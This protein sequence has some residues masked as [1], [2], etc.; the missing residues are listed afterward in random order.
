MKVTSFN[1]GKIMQ[2]LACAILFLSQQGALDSYHLTMDLAFLDSLYAH[3][4]DGL[5]FPALIETEA[6]FCSCTAGF[7]GGTSLWCPKKSWKIELDDPALLNASHLLLDAQYRDLT[8]MRNALAMWLARRLGRPASE[9]RHVELTVN[10]EP[11]GVYVQVEH[12]DEYFFQRNGIGEGPLFKSVSHEGRLAWQPCDSTLITGF[13]AKEGSEEDFFLV[14]RLIDQVNL[15]LPFLASVPD[16][17]AYAAVTLAICDTDALT[18]NYYIHLTPEGVWRFYPWDRDASFGNT[19]SGDYDSSWVHKTTT[20]T[21]SISPMTARLLMDGGNRELLEE[22]IEDLSDI[23]RLEMPGVIDSMQAA[24]RGSVEADPFYNGSVED[25]DEAVAVLR[26]AVIE[27]GAFLPEIEE[28]HHPLEPLSMTLSQWDLPMGTP[29]PVTVTVTYPQPV[30]NI[31]LTY[32]IDDGT[33]V[34]TWMEP[35]GRG[36]TTWTRTIELTTAAQHVQFAVR[37]GVSEEDGCN[38]VFSW[39]LYGLP[40]ATYRRVAAP[41]A[42][43]SAWPFRAE[44]LE[45]LNPVRHTPFLWSLPLVNGGS[46]PMD[47]SYFGFRAGSPQ[48]AAWACN[49]L[50]LDPGDTLL[51]TNNHDMLRLLYPDRTIVGDLV[52]D[53]P[54]EI[55]FLL[56]APSWDTASS[57][58]VGPEVQGSASSNLILSEVCYDGSAAPGDWIEIYNPGPFPADVSGGLLMDLQD[59]H[60]VLPE[61][62]I[63]EPG[64]FLVVCAD[65]SAFSSFYGSS[66]LPVEAL[67]FGLNSEHDG[68]SL[69]LDD[70]LCFSVNWDSQDWPIVSGHVLSLASP[71]LPMENPCSWQAV[72]MPGTPGARNPDWPG[73]MI[74]PVIGSLRPN[75]VTRT[76]TVDYT[77]PYLPAD[78]LIY[79]LSGRLVQPSAAVSD[80]TGTLTVELSRDL[81]PGVYFA[82]LRSVGSTATAKLILLPGGP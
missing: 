8:M 72:E 70:L 9:T 19:W 71:S 76:F 78:L 7:R 45:V 82:L 15:D 25:F 35:A 69:F 62:T 38:S 29:S 16:W 5:E 57:M 17:I 26:N 2:I 80:Y 44:D 56:I 34:Y 50:V 40:T 46:E 48:A 3:P 64:R 28:G 81:P 21:A 73:I 51:L 61:G 10:G 79:D 22:D 74:V 6:G 53:S 59:N 23:M 18:K 42:R 49:G 43:R 54:A 77:V 24:V 41:T 14:R 66:Q 13:E 33:E 75:P 32:C 68:V 52:L 12:V 37:T 47:L 67:D 1:G 39:P 11:Y 63:I 20:F 30:S 55:P 27:R 65:I 31:T 60:S 36:E 58:M 4:F